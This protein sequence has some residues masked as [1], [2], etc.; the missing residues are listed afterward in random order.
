M[1]HLLYSRSSALRQQRTERYFNRS[2]ILKAQPYSIQI[3]LYKNFRLQRPS[4]I[5]VWKYSFHFD[6][7]PVFR[8]AKVLRLINVTSNW[9]PCS[10]NPCQLNQECHPLMNN[11]S[12]HICLCK[13]NFTGDDCSVEDERCVFNYCA[14]EALCKPNYHS[15]LQG[16][17]APHCICPSGRYGARCY[18]EHDFCRT[19]P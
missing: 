14:A 1:V 2:K 17:V 12:Q 8:F 9:S 10:S 7:L 5:A 6:Y 16:N 15:L 11:K 13:A 3:E 4:L 19:N 18:I